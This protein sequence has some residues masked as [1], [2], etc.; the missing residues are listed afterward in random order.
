VLS[1]VSK[2]ADKAFIV[3]FLM[4]SIL[5]VFAAY[6]VFGCPAWLGA[7]CTIDA[8]NPFANLT[9]IA[10]FVW[11]I[12]VL[13]LTIND[14]AY[15]TLEGYTPPLSWMPWLK[16]WHIKRFRALTQQIATLSGDENRH[17]RSVVRRQLLTLYPTFESEI[18][19]TRFGNVLRAFE[20]YPRDVYGVDAIPMYLRLGSVIP[21]EFQAMIS[22]ARSQVDFFLNITVLF[23]GIAVGAIVYIVFESIAQRTW[24]PPDSG[25][26]FEAAIAFVLIAYVSYRLAIRQLTGWGDLVKSAFDCYLP[27]LAKQLGYVLP[28][29]ESGRREFWR[30]FVDGAFKLR[31]DVERPPSDGVTAPAAD[32]EPDKPVDTK[33]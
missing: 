2:L 5:A 11:I 4:P 13:L 16:R 20:V 32:G 24:W 26:T 25:A 27:D 30:Q 19:P 3:G 28:E 33:E 22:D 8:A 12:A 1:S 31:S 14:A 6:R 7:A 15:R 17:R 21:K 18:L 9:Y 10:L 29:T 23:T